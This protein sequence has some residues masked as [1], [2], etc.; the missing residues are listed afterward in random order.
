MGLWGGG[1][2]GVGW[3]VLLSNDKSWKKKGW[4]RVQSKKKRGRLLNYSHQEKRSEWVRRGG[5]EEE[6][7]GW[8]PTHFG[9]GN[10][11]SGVATD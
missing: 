3:T 2:G 9:L 5:G 8:P 10:I 11:C 6:V 1:W 7:G 4:E